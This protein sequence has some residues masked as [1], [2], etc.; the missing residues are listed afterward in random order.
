MQQSEGFSRANYT[1][2]HFVDNRIDLFPVVF[3]RSA[4]GLKGHINSFVILS[5]IIL[6]L[7]YKLIKIN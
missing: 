1:F 6:V 7:K 2:G 4:L 3:Y 5:S